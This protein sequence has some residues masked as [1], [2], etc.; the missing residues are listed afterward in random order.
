M[1]LLGQ[2]RRSWLLSALLFV[3]PAVFT[4]V[5]ITVCYSLFTSGW[6]TV[7]RFSASL[8]RFAI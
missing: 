2:R 3:M 7:A 6:L 5:S 8:L 1:R 4:F